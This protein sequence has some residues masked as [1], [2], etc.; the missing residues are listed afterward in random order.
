MRMRPHPDDQERS[1]YDVM[2]LSRKMAD[3]VRPPS[4]MGIGPE[5][6]I[7]GKTRP[8]R[9]YTT[10]DDPQVGEVLEQDLFNIVNIQKGMRSQG[11]GGVLRYSQQEARVQQ[12]HAELEL[13][14]DGKKG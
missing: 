14:L 5:V 10:T 13:Y 3:G 7:S 1:F 4:Y 6:D 9:L 11:L 8:A 2:V 12:F